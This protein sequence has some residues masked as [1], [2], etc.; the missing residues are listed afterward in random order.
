MLSDKFIALGEKYNTIREHVAAPYMRKSFNLPAVPEKAE[1]TV[2][3]LGFY[4]LWINGENI[5]KGAL[6]PYMSNPDQVMYYDRYDVTDKLNKGENVIGLML[7]NGMQNADTHVWD[8]D[9]NAFR[10]V[11]DCSRQKCFSCSR[12]SVKED[13]FR[14][15]NSE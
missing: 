13:T 9:K 8:F 4:V 2:C 15:I 14:R 11:R 10:S 5:T 1:I 12:W 6:A 3:G 7:G